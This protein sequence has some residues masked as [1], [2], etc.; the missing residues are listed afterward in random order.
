MKKNI[1]F[2]HPDRLSCAVPGTP[3]ETVVL[4]PMKGL[5]YEAHIWASRTVVICVQICQIVSVQT[6]KGNFCKVACC[7]LIEYC[8]TQI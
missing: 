3:P 4:G 7:S 5:L 6:Q 2:Q 8:Q 1:F